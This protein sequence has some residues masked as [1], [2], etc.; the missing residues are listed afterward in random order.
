MSEPLTPEALRAAFRKGADAGATA[1]G[2]AVSSAAPSV[3]TRAVTRS[4]TP[5]VNR[6]PGLCATCG[7]RVEV[8]AGVATV[9]AA[10]KWQVSHHAGRC[11]STPATPTAPDNPAVASITAG[12]GQ[13]Y[14]GPMPGIYTLETDSG[15]TTFRIR[16][17]PTTSD[18]APGS[19][20]L[21]YL[22]GPDNTSDY[23]GFAFVKGG[24][25]N[26]WR[27]FKEGHDDLLADAREFL[28]APDAAVVART[29]IRCSRLL[30]TPESVAA[31]IGP[32]C[33]TLG[34]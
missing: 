14:I 17:Q 2:A 31:G 1:E 32:R 33:E 30:T 24:R 15:H 7:F 16:V 12:N 21:E 8:G 9:N 22:T 34:W 5:I 11:P 19:T 13:V 20:V 26:V 6:Y 27:R 28:E 29:C 4:P 23:T 3:P 25:L 10:S 18:F